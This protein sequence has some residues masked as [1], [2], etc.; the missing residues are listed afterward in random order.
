MT[1]K[2]TL[3]NGVRIL[4]ERIG[5]VRSAS[6]GIWVGC[7][8][9]HEPP[10]LSGVSHFIE[11]IVFKGTETRSA[12]EIASI[13]D[14]VGGQ[15]NAFTTKE[16]T[17]FYARALDKHLGRTL[18]VLCDMFF[19]PRI[20]PKDVKTERGVILEEIGMYE[21]APEELVAERLFSAV[22][23]GSPL[24]KNILGSS[25]TLKRL[26]APRIRGYMAGHYS[27]ERTVVSISGSFSDRD[28]GYLKE[29]F[30]AM[31]GPG[32]PESAPAAYRPAFTVRNKPIEQNHL[33]IGFPAPGI[34][35]GDRYALQLF[36]CI[37]GGGA[38][39][40]LF[41]SVRES[42]GLCY[43]IYSFTAS[44]EDAGLLGVYAA[45]SRETEKPALALIREDLLRLVQDGPSP[46][47]LDRAREQIVSGVLMGLESTG[48]RMSHM[49]RS[50]LFFGRVPTAEEI[51][52][53]YDAVTLGQV[54][55]V[56]E[57]VLTPSGLSFSAVG[58][59][60]VPSWYR[61]ILTGNAG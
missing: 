48:T 12:A 2:I 3:E 40:R 34:R 51:T 15:V 22:F 42:R 39:S 13:M 43:S 18:D 4:C 31:R 28:I 38:S 57:R 5:Y 17:C 41:Q 25:G 29:R 11:H 32:A 20:A 27:P 21:D 26:T 35:S 46:E 45:L 8:S 23:K 54:R 9:R 24:E 30:S 19:N 61:K 37:L 1:E 52:E 14:G 44:H 59:V 53:R 6:V 16:S 60:R 58:R 33:C 7:G 47:E 36:N 10:E 50:E 49:A 56:A 55:A